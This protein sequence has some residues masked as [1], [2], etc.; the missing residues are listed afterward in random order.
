MLVISIIVLVL[1]A[2]AALPSN[3]GPE[4]RRR[5]GCITKR[6]LTLLGVWASLVIVSIGAIAVG[7]YFTLVSGRTARYLETSSL[8][9]SFMILLHASPAL[10]AVVIVFAWLFIWLPR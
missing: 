2:A 5:L 9:Q 1:M 10:V 4:P 7:F 3:S 6:F 8:M